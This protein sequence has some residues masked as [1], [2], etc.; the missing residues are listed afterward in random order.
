MME[1]IRRGGL[2]MTQAGNGSR[3][4]VLSKEFPLALQ[5]RVASLAQKR[6]SQEAWLREQGEDIVVPKRSLEVSWE[7]VQ[8]AFDAMP[9]HLRTVTDPA[10]FAF[11]RLVEADPTFLQSTEEDRLSKD[12]RP[13]QRP[14]AHYLDWLTKRFL[15][16]DLPY[17]DLDEGK[18]L[19]ALRDYHAAKSDRGFP[20]E[21]R[22]IGRFRH[23][24]DVID[25]VASHRKSKQ[26]HV[27]PPITVADIR[28]RMGDLIEDH[29]V[30]LYDGSGIP[31]SGVRLMLS[32][33]EAGTRRQR[34]F[35]IKWA[36]E[37]GYNVVETVRTTAE[38]DAVV[39]RLKGTLDVVHEGDGGAIIHARS[40]LAARAVAVKNPHD[41]GAKACSWCTSTANDEWYRHYARKGALVA[42]LLPDGRRAQYNR[43]EA[44]L[45]NESDKAI[46]Y[47]A[48]EP[49]R[50]V[51][52]DRFPALAFS[53]SKGWAAWGRGAWTADT[54]EGARFRAELAD[55]AFS[56]YGKG[57]TLGKTPTLKAWNDAAYSRTLAELPGISDLPESLIDRDVLREGVRRHPEDLARLPT[58]MID[59]AFLLDAIEEPPGNGKHVGPLL[60]SAPQGLIDRE[61][62]LAAARKTVF[63]GKLADVAAVIPQAVIDANFIVE[64]EALHRKDGRNPSAI[65][66]LIERLPKDRWTDAVV[67]LALAATGGGAIAT[68]PPRLLTEDV[69]MRAVAAS[70]SHTP[71]TLAAIPV[72]LRTRN[73]CIA[74]LE[75][76]KS[77][78]TVDHVPASIM[79]SE[80]AK[81]AIRAVPETIKRI[82]V[83]HID[84]HIAVEA[85]SRTSLAA[86]PDVLRTEAVCLA[87]VSARA[88]DI[89]HVSDERRTKPVALAMLESVSSKMTDGRPGADRSAA[90]SLANAVS[91]VGPVFGSTLVH[92]D[93]WWLE[94]E[95]R[96]R[97]IC[98]IP[99]SV[100]DDEV[101]HAIVRVSPDSL[102][103]L[104][105]E[106]R[107][108]D[109]CGAAIKT[110]ENN[111]GENPQSRSTVLS[112]PPLRFIVQHVPQ[113]VV[114]GDLFP[115]E[116]I[117]DLIRQ[118]RLRYADI[119]PALRTQEM[120]DA[121]AHTLATKSMWG[122]L[123]D[124][125]PASK[126]I[127]HDPLLQAAMTRVPEVALRCGSRE[128]DYVPDGLRTPA[129]ID[130]LARCGSEGLAKVRDRTT[131]E[132][133]RQATK[134]KPHLIGSAPPEFRD[135]D[136]WERALRDRPGL[137][138]LAPRDEAMVSR[139]LAV[140]ALSR[141]SGSNAR[142]ENLPKI[143][144][145]FANVHRPADEFALDVFRDGVEQ[146]ASSSW[147]TAD[148]RAWLSGFREAVRSVVIWSDDHAPIRVIDGTVAAVANDPEAFLRVPYEAMGRIDPRYMSESFACAVVARNPRAADHLPPTVVTEA[149]ERVALA[150]RVA[151]Y[152]LDLNG[153]LDDYRAGL[154][155]LA[156][157]SFRK[158]EAAVSAR[159][160]ALTQ[161]LLVAAAERSV[162]VVGMIDPEWKT[163]E[164]AKRLLER[165][166]MVAGYL[167]DDLKRHVTAEQWSEY[168]AA[169][170]DG[171]QSL[172]NVPPEARTIG[173]CSAAVAANLDNMAH[174]PEA[175]I[176]AS[177][178]RAVY[179]RTR[180][181]TF[182]HDYLSTHYL[183]DVQR[184]AVAEHVLSNALR[185]VPD[186]VIDEVARS[187]KHPTERMAFRLSVQQGDGS[188]EKK[189]PSIAFGR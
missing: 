173:V 165:N 89:V 24:G 51:L 95:E 57:K 187:I 80:I 45:M 103:V 148:K 36:G 91:E 108:V 116:A 155:D 92:R 43:P 94:A 118:V 3:I 110:L 84:E 42:F 77:A 23:I 185:R 68:V 37:N 167:P 166:V 53:L 54:Q 50:D 107:T 21:Q 87:A 70:P 122:Y 162:R 159:P 177:L 6:V 146:V 4:D 149:V 52:L 161:D 157:E 7:Q 41:P 26:E 121:F 8:G 184:N 145:E 49:L 90:R 28:S 115:D 35:D 164:F 189:E 144:Q 147:T 46:R 139:D 160:E 130:A 124:S 152:G 62:A 69:A 126:A 74:A 114:F 65:M 71:E 111:W 34:K 96:K 135:S 25:A 182:V 58:G 186:S 88:N 76:T 29:M 83:E 9:E 63:G 67:D 151:E 5:K 2:E 78:R 138:M 174:V 72:D 56:L 64:V 10:A 133:W 22:D 86:I 188:P 31:I 85:A 153:S 156:T 30:S 132:H 137:I 60:K 99:T 17:E 183:P 113:E 169:A 127:Q 176:D 158:F 128:M 38:L 101:A 20:A 48:L 105:V 47:T 106:R 81:V 18:A 123:S 131:A 40:H 168:V 61:V 120:A 19:E 14:A 141:M 154:A 32:E 179:E 55:E 112:L 102:G 39:A 13:A 125:D 172:S 33:I 175:V 129:F 1:G 98:A 100:V 109:V 11:Q 66:G 136:M 82:P 119:P 117:I 163:E 93:A 75:K 73:V 170:H 143:V 59:K 27:A 150:A 15:A 181:E 97:L 104:P 16:G 142:P 140:W 134:V 79:D 12:G 171:F 44:M 178:V 180:E